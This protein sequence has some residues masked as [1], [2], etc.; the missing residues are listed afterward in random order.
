MLLS[1]A[2]GGSA[3]EREYHEIRQKLLSDPKIRELLPPF[4]RTCRTLSQ[5]WP[6]IQNVDGSYAGRR[7]H[8]WD[9]FAPL[10][11]DLES[12]SRAP[13]DTTVAESLRHLDEDEI[14]A[15]WQ[16]ALDRRAA[17][18][19][20]AIT[21]ART[22]IESVCKVIL[23]D[24]HVSYPKN[25]DL[26]QL[27]HIVA[28]ELNLAPQQHDEAIFKRILGGANTVVEGLATIRNRYGD[29]HGKGKKPVKASAR[30]AELTVNL[31]GTMAAFLAATW[32]SRKD[33]K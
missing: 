18:P 8:V 20:G 4:V 19:E 7:Q 12:R 2:T 27:Y 10:L 31:A 28:N 14:S 32:R 23:D 21:A 29:S 30:H 6:Y 22:L 13:A 33:G 9:G 17:D 11:D 1:R 5:F 3:D 16:R 26:P 24:L 15:F 25:P